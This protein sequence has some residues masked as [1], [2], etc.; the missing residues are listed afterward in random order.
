MTNV[1]FPYLFIGGGLASGTAIET[2]MAEGVSGKDIAL[3]G[4]EPELPYNRPSL[5]KGFLADTESRDSLF[6]EPQSYYVDHGV[7]V[8]LA[9]KVVRL[10]PR[11]LRLVT[12]HDELM[13]FDRALI[14]TGSL[15]R[16]LGVPGNDLGQIFSLRTLADSVAI[17]TAAKTAQRA[18]IVGAGFIGLEVAA[19]LAQQGLAVTVLHRGTHL[20]DRFANP[21][22]ATF[23]YDYFTHQGVTFRFETTVD[24]FL[25]ASSAVTTVVTDTGEELP[26]DLVIVGIGV[27][28]ALE[29]LKDQALRVENGLVVDEQLETAVPG[30]FAAGDIAN[31]PDVIFNRKRRRIEHWDHAIATGKQAARNMLGKGEEFRHVSYFFSDMFDLSFELF[32]D[33]DDATEVLFEGSTLKKTAAAWYLRAGKLAAY[34]AISRPDSEKE[35]M[36]SWIESGRAVTRDNLNQFIRLIT[37]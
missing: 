7:T 5:S 25:G 28:L 27:D 37:K 23:F 26:A 24:H 21:A 32:G 17:K 34:F 13:T 18:V 15:P 9:T 16:R 8:K 33:T 14:A 31:F 36:Q 19:N 4:L 6:I 1:H 11:A 30:I 22:M 35:Q 12:D 3:V 29:F 10:Q 2:L 20:L